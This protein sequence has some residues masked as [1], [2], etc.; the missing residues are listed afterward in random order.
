MMWGGPCYV[1]AS[2][3]LIP[4]GEIHQVQG[5][6]VLLDGAQVYRAVEPSL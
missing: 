4:P 5:L 2:R 3:C 1:R 6:W